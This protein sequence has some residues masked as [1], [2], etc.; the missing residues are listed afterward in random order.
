MKMRL[1]KHPTVI[2]QN[3]VLLLHREKGQIRPHILHVSC[4]SYPTAGS[5]TV[6]H[7][8]ILDMNTWQKD[9]GQVLQT[10]WF[11]IFYF[12]YNITLYLGTVVFVIAVTF[13]SSEVGAYFSSHC[14][15][16]GSIQSSPSSGVKDHHSCKKWYHCYN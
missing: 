7:V 13:T 9:P 2:S 3:P 10:T 4:Q 16:S 8:I 14:P 15:S 11:V 6:G 12:G 1:W 5:A